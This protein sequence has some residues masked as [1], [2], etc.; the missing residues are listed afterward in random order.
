MFTTRPLRDNRHRNH[1]RLNR[2]KNQEGRYSDH[3]RHIR[4]CR[5]RVR[6]VHNVFEP[7]L[8]Q[9]LPDYSG[10]SISYCVL[11]VSEIPN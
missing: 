2:N 3:R 8:Q 1:L 7:H 6:T 5:I 11:V 10:F 9:Q 4:G